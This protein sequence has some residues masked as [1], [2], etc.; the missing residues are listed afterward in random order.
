MFDAPKRKT[1]INGRSERIRGIPK[2]AAKDCKQQSKIRKTSG[3]EVK[4]STSPPWENK[5]GRTGGN[6]AVRTEGRR[7]GIGGGSDWLGWRGHERQTEKGKE[8][9]YQTKK[10]ID[11]GSALLTAIRQARGERVKTLQNRTTTRS[12]SSG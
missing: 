12:L 3:P 8:E 7:R 9:D 10:N 2:Q 4:P 5:K 6:W 11:R 1:G